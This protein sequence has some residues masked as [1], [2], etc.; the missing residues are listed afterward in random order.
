MPKKKVKIETEVNETTN[1]TNP[2]VKYEFVKPIDLLELDLGRADLNQV[3]D[4][5]NQVIKKVNQ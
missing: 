4:R 3:V 1:S 5:L 2:D